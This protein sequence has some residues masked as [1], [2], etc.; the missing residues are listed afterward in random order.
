MQKERE[1]FMKLRRMTAVIMLAAMVLTGCGGKVTPSSLLKEAGKKSNSAKS[2]EMAVMLDLDASIGA[3]GMSMDMKLNMNMDIETTLDPMAVHGQGTMSMEAMGQ[4]VEEKIEMYAEQEGD[5]FYTYSQTG[6]TGWEKEESDSLSNITT[7]YSEE[8]LNAMADSMELAEDTETVNDKECYKLS[9]NIKGED[10]DALME[11]VMAGMDGTEM[12]GDLD[13]AGTEIPMVYYIAKDD[14]AP[15]KMT[16]DMKSVMGKALEETMKES[17][18][19]TAG[20]EV[21]TDITTCNME[22]SFTSFDQTESITVPA[23]AKES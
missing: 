18:G 20:E 23:E 5:K 16:I 3:M 21:T 6:S 17:M 11:G 1:A 7:L 4:S 15:V 12:V 19:D 22:I 14:K 8:S 13:L 10:L 9:G 2:A